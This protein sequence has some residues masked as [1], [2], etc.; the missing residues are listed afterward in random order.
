MTIEMQQLR[1]FVAVAE[2]K[3]FGRVAIRLHMTQPPLS[4]AIQVLETNISA[5]LFARTKRRVVLT[6]VG[7][8][9]LPELQ[10]STL[11]DLVR[12]AASSESDLLKLAF[13]STADYIILPSLLREFREA[14]PHVQI[15]LKE[16][17]SDLQFEQLGLGQI[18]V[19]LL[20]P[21]LPDQAKRVLDYFPVLSE[22]LIVAIPDGHSA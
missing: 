12:R 5:M 14:Y 10:A 8:V 22:L 15:D 4:Q 11:P 6:P 3:H 13:V 19:S 9:F 7:L 21:P 1:Y 20:I 18:D 16:V 2:E 17:T